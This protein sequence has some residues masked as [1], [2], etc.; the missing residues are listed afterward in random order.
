MQKQ[1]KTIIQNILH[2]SLHQSEALFEK[3]EE[4]VHKIL[5]EKR[6]KSKIK[7]GGSVKSAT[8]EV[9]FLKL[10][11]QI[12]VMSF[13]KLHKISRLQRQVIK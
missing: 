10:T 5:I 11:M 7:K 8:K 2:L 9:F 12:E 6:K 3:N 1:K 13:L 4:Y